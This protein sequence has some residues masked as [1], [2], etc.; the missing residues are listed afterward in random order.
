MTAGVDRKPVEENSVAV[1]EV[2]GSEVKTSETVKVAEKRMQA[3]GRK[4]SCRPW[5]SRE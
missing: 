4:R 1:P 2:K 3:C 5:R